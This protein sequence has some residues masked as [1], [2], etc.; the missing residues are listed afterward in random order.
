ML[1]H[2][3]VCDKIRVEGAAHPGRK[4]LM[5]MAADSFRLDAWDA[6]NP[7]FRFWPATTREQEVAL[8]LRIVDYACAAGMIWC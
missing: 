4:R 2:Q 5:Q 7:V 8:Q 1:T 3:Q 6:R